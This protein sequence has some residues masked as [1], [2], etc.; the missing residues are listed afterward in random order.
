[1]FESV[2]FTPNDA[3]GQWDRV[4]GASTA[5]IS[6][7]RLAAF[8]N[9]RAH[10]SALTD[11]LLLYLQLAHRRAETVG[12]V[13]QAKFRGRDGDTFPAARPFSTGRH[14]LIDRANHD[15]VICVLDAPRKEPG[16]NEKH[17]RD[18][19]EFHGGKDVSFTPRRNLEIRAGK[20]SLFPPHFRCRPKDRRATFPDYYSRGTFIHSQ[21]PSFADS[22]ARNE[23]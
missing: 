14:L 12:L 11:F 7:G 10:G 15:L 9:H 6:A 13:T 18:N 1:M 23:R 2:P 4:P 17:R 3:R 5:K 20:S 21:P 22:N 19:R 8:G 16:E